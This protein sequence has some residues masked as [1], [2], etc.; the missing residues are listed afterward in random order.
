M[1][2]RFQDLPWHDATI[3]AIEIDRRRPGLAD[4]VSLSM[5]WP[6]DRYS[7]IKFLE[8]YGL[9]AMMNYG[10]IAAETVR[11]AVERDDTDGLGRIRDRWRNLDVDLS[12]LRSF[13]IETNSTAST[14]TVFARDWQ[15]KRGG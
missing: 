2:L 5:R 11:T 3:L 15:E 4:E 9:E 1:S 6:D 14:I 8:C 12:W 10:V 13:T 7:Q